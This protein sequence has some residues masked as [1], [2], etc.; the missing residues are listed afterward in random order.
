[1]VKKTIPQSVRASVYKKYSPRCTE[2]LCYIGCGQ[3]ITPFTFTCGHV[4]AEEN[5]GTISID[6]LRPICSLRSR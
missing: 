3:V 4:I 6:N 5:G 2:M 1:M